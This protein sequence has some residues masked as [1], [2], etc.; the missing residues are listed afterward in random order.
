MARTVAIGHQDYE[1]VRMND[2]FYI[3]KTDFIRVWWNSGDMVTLITRPRRFGKTLNMSMTEKFFSVR[4]AGRQDLFEG[5]KVWEQQDLRHLQGTYPVIAMTF[6]GIK[7]T[8]Y[9]S[10]RE[11]ICRVIEN[12]YNKNDFLM[13]G[14]LLNEK[15]KAYYNQ[16]KADMDDSTA[17]ASLNN[18]SD[19]L[20]RYYGKKVVIL[21]DEYDTPMQEAYTG[22][23]W[24][25]MVSFTRN[26]FNNTFKTNPHLERALLTGI[27][28]VS[29]ESVFSDL[30][31]L[32]VISTTSEKY[33]PFFGFTEEEV[34]HALD[35]FGLSDKRE[36][37]KL[38]YDG[39]TFG[40][41]SDIYNPWSILNYLKERHAAPYWANTSSNH[42]VSRLIQ[43]SSAG[44]K[45]DF[46]M[47]LEGGCVETE[48]EEQIV[49]DQLDKDDKAI[50][51]LLVASGYLTV[52]QVETMQRGY[53]EWQQIYT[54][55]LTNFEVK[56]MFRQMVNGWFA[57]VASHYNAFIRALL[58]GD[59]DAM[60]EYMNRISMSVFSYF[61]TAGD[62]EQTEP[63][64]FYHGFVLGLL[65]DLT[66]SYRL[67][68]NR[69]SGFGRYD[70]MLLPKQ[71][72]LDGI[73]IEFKVYNP[74]RE[75]NLQDTAANA[76][77]QIEQKGYARELLESGLPEKRIREYGFAFRGK[78]VFIDQ[79]G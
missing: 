58:L 10:A 1:T 8:N 3:D 15:E 40:K 33:A 48:I 21:L 57:K 60:N 6:A 4:Y 38:W 24:K 71:K 67:T 42:M 44:I 19:Y 31:N 53:E 5:M 76:L 12:L 70:V 50:W 75:K 51:S 27:T 9:I 14:S 78:E 65:V 52:R 32:V 56:I 73:I 69:E 64:R 68:S 37:V 23:Y 49:Y 25:E 63:E 22:G 45:D 74:R 7:D 30:N 29:K 46:Y 54:L 72:H 34:F 77:R 11:S 2:Y 35:E 20:E 13:K 41:K 36:E 16:V 61:D 26:L 18:L 43:Q 55:S 79:S 39:F 17:A 28:R 66:D 47:L 62:R 59:L